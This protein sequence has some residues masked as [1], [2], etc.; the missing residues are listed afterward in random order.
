VPRLSIVIPVWR[1]LER[2]EDTLVSV[3]EN[4]PDDSEVVVVLAEAYDDPYDLKDEIHFL[5]APPQASLVELANLGIEAS[6]APIVH[7]LACGAQVQEGWTDP[8]FA[9]F[10]D[11]WVAAVAP[12]VLEKDHPE[13]VVS[14][15]LTYHRGG[16]QKVLGQGSPAASIAD[17]RAMVLGP[18]SV[19][20]FYRKSALESVGRFSPAAGDE[21]AALDL[22]LRLA[23]VG[24]RAVR[25]PHSTVLADT[26][27]CGRRGAFRR[28]LQAERLFWRWAPGFGWFRSL[29]L[30]AIAVLTSL[31]CSLGNLTILG[32]LLGRTL[33][34]CWLAS[35]RR[36]YRELQRLRQ[37]V[38][39]AATSATSPHFRAVAQ[40]K[41]NGVTAAAESSSARIPKK[42]T[43]V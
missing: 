7:L 10:A 20:A 15:G 3:L 21:L 1:N 42:K 33:G 26:G 38:R 12:L 8:V 39:D 5:Q 17:D 18:H 25:E 31:A 9:H 14:A 30:H 32:E 43:A 4:R 13:R 28:A 37:W 34:L 22:A 35:G 2:L 36:H 23:Y 19:A 16:R 11:P 41:A 40:P 29:P 27:A 24:F 6:Q